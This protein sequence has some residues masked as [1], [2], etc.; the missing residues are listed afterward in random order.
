MISVAS[1]LADSIGPYICVL[2]THIDII[3]D[4]T[5]ELTQKLSS[6]ATK[7]K[8]VIFEDRLGRSIVYSSQRIMHLHSPIASIRKFADI[9][10]TVKQQYAGGIYRIVEWADI[11]NAHAVSGPGIVQGLKEVIHCICTRFIIL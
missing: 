11:T 6:L 9:G 5:P 3:E 10:N 8:F 7:H 2:K 4:F 1:Q